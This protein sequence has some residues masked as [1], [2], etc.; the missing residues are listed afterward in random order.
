MADTGGLDV[1]VIHA[2]WCVKEGS[3]VKSWRRRF[4]VLRTAASS[5]QQAKGE[6]AQ[7]GATHILLY[8]RSKQDYQ[9][10]RQPRGTMPIVENQTK[11]SLE[12]RKGK[13]TCILVETPGLVRKLLFL[14]EGPDSYNGPQRARDSWHEALTS[15]RSPATVF[16]R[17]RLDTLGRVPNFQSE[18][19]DEASDEEYDGPMYAMATQE[20]PSESAKSD[21]SQPMYARANSGGNLQIASSMKKKGSPQSR[22]TNIRGASVKFKVSEKQP[23]DENPEKNDEP[24]TKADADVKDG[25]SDDDSDASAE[26]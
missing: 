1:T 16:G 15:L 23:G 7:I 2:G 17:L 9:E 6:G 24:R 8:Y 21:Y 13:G 3:K 12:E 4:F 19:E 5:E 26:F 11:V 14:A 25:N 10:R 20:D 22:L 18:D